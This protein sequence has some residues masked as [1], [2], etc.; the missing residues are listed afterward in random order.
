MGLINSEQDGKK[1]IK[2]MYNKQETHWSM[3]KQ[4]NI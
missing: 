3:A 1:E 4:A 2:F